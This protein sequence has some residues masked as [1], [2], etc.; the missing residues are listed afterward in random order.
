MEEP[1]QISNL[2]DFIFCPASIYFHNLYGNRDPFIYQ[3][4]DQ[5]NGKKAHENI[6]SGGYSSRKGV[7][8]GI[9]V[10]SDRYGIIGKIDIY[11]SN[12][13]QLIERK[14]SIKTIYD[15]YVFQL[16]AQ[17]FCMIEMGYTV[18][19]LFLYSLVDNK[20]YAV[21]LPEDNPEMLMKFLDLIQRMK[22]FTLEFF[23]QTNPEKCARC[24]Y[25]PAC[26]RGLR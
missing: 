12:R 9:G 22:G 26:D 8:S 21:P 20:K 25:E 23:E 16:Y 24:I 14:R 4:S 15:G 13:Q 18:K 3:N 7:M 19:K 10:Y 6:D 2:N 17:C 1:I 11:D 5:I